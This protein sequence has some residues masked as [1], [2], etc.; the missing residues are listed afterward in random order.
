MKK[1]A[2]SL[3]RG[4]ASVLGLVAAA[5]LLAAPILAGT[6]EAQEKPRIVMLGGPLW[7]PFFGAMKKGGDDAARDLNVIEW[8]GVIGELLI[9]FVPFACHQ[10]NVSRAGQRNGAIDRLGAI[11][12][13]F[14][15]IRAKTLF[16]FGDNRA[17]VFLAWIVRRDDGVIGELICHL[18]H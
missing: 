11:D 14:V 4:G 18:R 6:A 3:V 12:N 13:F 8:D 17:R 15:M 5:C 9:V 7:D 10:D 16:G 1:L 2:N